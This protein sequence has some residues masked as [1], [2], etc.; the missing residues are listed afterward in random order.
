MILIPYPSFGEYNRVFNVKDTYD[1][2]CEFDEIFIEDKI[3]NASNIVFVNPNNPTGTMLKTSW[4]LKMIDNYPNKFFI[5]DESFIE[6]SDEKSIIDHLELSSRNNVIVI[7]S[8]SK[9]YG[10]PGIRLGFI[11]SCNAKLI[12]KISSKVPIWNLNSLSEFFMEIILKNKRALDKSIE[13][14]KIDR[15]LFI[16]SLNNLKFVEKAFN[17]GGNFIL[18]KIN[19]K[20]TVSNLSEYLIQN[21]FIYIKD[22]SDK[23]N[24]KPNTF[25]RVAVRNPIDN[26]ILIKFLKEIK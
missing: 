8:M 17:S 15:E 14:T 5:V 22:V 12:S 9:T 13:K 23:F 7:R 18:F 21:H 4:I 1:D 11:Y 19:N 10:L 25:F 16:N 20:L 24:S 6:F 26:N 2:N 3:K